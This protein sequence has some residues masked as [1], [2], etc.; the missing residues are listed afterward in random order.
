MVRSVTLVAAIALLLGATACGSTAPKAAPDVTGERLDVAENA[1]DASGLR[2]R[3]VG[4]G[5]LGI[6]VRS[7]WT[8]CRQSPRPGIGARSVTLFVARACPAARPVVV[9]DVIGDDLDD[10][11]STLEQAGLR[12]SAESVEGD[13][14]LVRSLWTVCDQSPAPGLRGRAVEL[15]VAHDCWDY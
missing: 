1:L 4:G 12:V 5:A 15:Y 14:I 6:V 9:P 10:A 8:V 7:H 11:E 3:T 2:Y 13:P